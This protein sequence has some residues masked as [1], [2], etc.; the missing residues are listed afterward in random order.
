MCLSCSN[1]NL[2][3]SHHDCFNN[4]VSWW[5]WIETSCDEFCNFKLLSVWILL[6]WSHL[7]PRINQWTFCILV[8]LTLNLDFQ[9]ARHWSDVVSEPLPISRCSRLKPG[10]HHVTPW[11]WCCRSKS[12]PHSPQSSHSLNHSPRGLGTVQGNDQSKVWKFGKN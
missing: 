4:L 3:P 7:S 11:L 1:C 8:S 2:Q 6:S 9:V 12:F 5:D 10:A